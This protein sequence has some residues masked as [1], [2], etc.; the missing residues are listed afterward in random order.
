MNR[1]KSIETIRP[2]SAAHKDLMFLMLCCFGCLLSLLS[3]WFFN[4]FELFLASHL[5]IF[6]PFFPLQNYSAFCLIRS[7]LSVV[8]FPL[9][10][11]FFSVI[12]CLSGL[13]N[14]SF[15]PFL[16]SPLHCLLSSSCLAGSLLTLLNVRAQ[17]S[18]CRAAPSPRGQKQLVSLPFPSFLAASVCLTVC[19]PTSDTPPPPY[20]CCSSLGRV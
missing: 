3:V 4:N 7:L 1:T 6:C 14:F 8:L 16:P 20:I 18:P 12:K 13:F 2:R 9:S 10:C 5:P 17:T 15:F 11:F 19:L